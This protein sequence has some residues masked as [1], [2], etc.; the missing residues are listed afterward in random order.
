MSKKIRLDVSGLGSLYENSISSMSTHRMFLKDNLT[1]GLCVCGELDAVLRVPS[2]SIPKNAKL[3]PYVCEEGSD[4][5]VKKSEFFVFSRQIEKESSSVKIVAYDAVY[6]AEAQYAQ[7]GD[8]GNWPRLAKTVMAEIATRTGASICSD[9][10]AF[11]NSA[12]QYTINF[13]GIIITDGSTT[14]YESDGETTMRDVAGY[15][16]GLYAGNWIIDNNG[17][18]RLVRFSDIP[19]ETHYLVTEDGDAI[20]MGGVRLLV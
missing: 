18:W 3:T 16:A 7:A 1:I 5:W 12:P 8:L 19:P 6:K 20:V 4:N 15:I 10:V 17:E 13:P 14:T 11:M 9:T 2:S